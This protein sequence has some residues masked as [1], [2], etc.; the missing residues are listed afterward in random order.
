MRKTQ[1]S[2]ANYGD[3]KYI[4]KLEVLGGYQGR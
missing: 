2:F 3:E 4:H 1:N